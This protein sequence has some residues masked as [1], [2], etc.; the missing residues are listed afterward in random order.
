VGVGLGKGLDSLD[1]TQTTGAVGLVKKDDYTD[2]FILP[3]DSC[4][5]MITVLYDLN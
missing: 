3:I 2:R 5:E 4:K 1:G